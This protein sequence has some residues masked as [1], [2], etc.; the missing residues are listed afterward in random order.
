MARTAITPQ[1]ILRTSNGLTPSY[2]AVDQANGN[3]FQNTGREILHVKNTN[4][5]TR[6][7]TVATPGSVDGLAV[8]DP[9]FVIP[10]TT[11]DKF[12]GPFPPGVY[13]QNDGNVWLDW[14]ASSGVTI[15]VLR[16]P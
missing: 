15:A 4:G 7:L 12:I 14:D 16:L 1:V 13:N 2:G 6:T 10:A 5:A 3:Q 9:T 11:G 8:A